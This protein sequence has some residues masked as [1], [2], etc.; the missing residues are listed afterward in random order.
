M[1]LEVIEVMAQGKLLFKLLPKWQLCYLNKKQL[2]KVQRKA[3][4]LGR[5]PAVI[6]MEMRIKG[7]VSGTWIERERERERQTDRET[8]RQR[9]TESTNVGRCCR[10]FGSYVNKT[11]LPRVQVFKTFISPFLVCRHSTTFLSVLKKIR[12]FIVTFLGDFL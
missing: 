7:T 1:P 11:I 6:D 4:G 2:L 9:D 5:G 12:C 10:I 3:M 8:D